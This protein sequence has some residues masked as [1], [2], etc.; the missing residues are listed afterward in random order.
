MHRSG[1]SAVARLLGGLG[2]DAG[3]AEGLIGPTDHN[4]HGH[5]EVQALV[6]LNDRLLA[7]LGGTWVAPP[8][9]EPDRQRKLAGGAFG[10]EAARL[11]DDH[12][13]EHLW[14]WKDPRACLLLPFW[15]EV[16]DGQHAALVVVRHPDAVAA[17]LEA[18]DGL[19]VA[20]GRQ[21]WSTY[22]S[23]LSAS[24]EGVATMT[25]VYDV[26]LADAVRRSPAGSECR[27][28]PFWRTR[29]VPHC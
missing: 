18:R 3:P 14:L 17:S 10:T 9:H 20:Y 25:V 21:L 24:L 22:L 16:L 7:E 28:T 23:T 15:L 29:Q 8:P 4:P 1:T 6:D 13:G 27:A 19:P 26:L 5:F 12:F 2:L 11:L